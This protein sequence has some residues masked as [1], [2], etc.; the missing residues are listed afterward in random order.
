MGYGKQQG[1]QHGEAAIEQSNDLRALP[2]LNKE[3]R[4]LGHST[5]LS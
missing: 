5:N 4:K 3:P 1:T 2:K